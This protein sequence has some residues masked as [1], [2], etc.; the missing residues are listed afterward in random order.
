[1]EEKQLDNNK[2][3]EGIDYVI[4][5][6]CGER[7][8]DQITLTHLKTHG[9]TFKDIKKEFPNVLLTSI[10]LKNKIKQNKSKTKKTNCVFCG[11]EIEIKSEISIQKAVCSTCKE[12]GLKVKE[13]KIVKCYYCHEECEVNL[14]ASSKYSVCSECKKKG[15]KNPQAVKTGGSAYKNGKP[16]HMHNPKIKEKVRKKL[17]K[18]LKTNKDKIITQRKKTYKQKT[19]YEVP[20]QNPEVLEK[21]KKTCKERLGVEYALQSQLVKEKLKSTNLEKYGCEWSLQNKNIRNKGKK[22]SLEKYGADHWTKTNEGRR[23]LRNLGIKN[24]QPDIKKEAIKYGWELVDDNYYNAFTPINFKCLK[25]Q[26]IHKTIWN[27]I[28]Q[29]WRCPSCFPRT[30][31]TSVLEQELFNFIESVYEK[32]IIQND[33][34]VLKSHEIDIFLPDKNIAIEFDGLYWHNES[35]GCDKNYH[36]NKTIECENKNIQLIH[37]F[38]DEWVFKQD[39]VKS[40]L[41]EILG[42]SN[43]LRIHAR[44]CIIKEID[45]K[46]KNEFLDAFHIQGADKSVIKLG[47]FYNDELISVM[48]FSHGNIS[49]GSKLIDGVWELNRFCSNPNYHIPGIASKLLKFFQR[50]YDWKEIFS[51]ADRRWSIGNVYEKLGFEFKYATKPNYWYIKGYQRIYRFKLRKKPDDPKN[52]TEW[53][54]R[55]KEGYDRIW[56]CGHLKYVM[57]RKEIKGDKK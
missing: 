26:N 56:D 2:S 14:R 21:M 4:C 43:S 53:E 10:N 7:F 47:A 41:K 48:T 52:I 30:P 1:M 31:G 27:Y 12:K 35:M 33:R 8:A 9:K 55:R 44:K 45:S 40:R 36:L 57:R 37:I 3:I 13:T 18:A 38:E 20:A 42:I 22:T 23:K 39:I 15:L 5:P 6:Y 24:F 16:H 19:G 34:N 32:Q 46:T 29:G 28:Q 17:L 25:C 50:N 51:Y 11:K 49:K 54:L